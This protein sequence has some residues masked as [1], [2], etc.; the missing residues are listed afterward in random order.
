MNSLEDFLTL[1]DVDN[2]EEEVF[3]SQRLGK[4][5]I[6]AMTSDEFSDYQKR[7]RGKISKKGANFDLEKFNLLIVAG[8]VTYPDF[9]NADFLK[10]ANCNTALE[11]INKKLL[12]GEITELSRQIQK[13]SGF[14]TDINDDV[15]EAKN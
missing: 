15:E 4:F 9:N 13:L 8:Q 7:C 6:K 14:D 2:I 5:K 3:V 10:K 12:V 1:P 11:F